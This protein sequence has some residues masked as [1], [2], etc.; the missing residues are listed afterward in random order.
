M[1]RLASTA[2]K[3][4]KAEL[5]FCDELTGSGACCTLLSGSY[6][7]G[8]EHQHSDVDVIVIGQA[9]EAMRTPDDREVLR[10]LRYIDG[11]R[12]EIEYYQP[13]FIA[14][15][16]NA[17]SEER[18]AMAKG[19]D[20]LSVLGAY[21]LSRALRLHDGVPLSGPELAES[22]K[23]QLSAAG[24]AEVV[25][26][27]AVHECDA[28]VD[29][30][31]GL[32]AAGDL[33]SAVLA[34]AV[35]LGYAIDACLA[36]HGQLTPGAKWRYRKYLLLTEREKPGELPMTAEKC[37]RLLTLADL[38]TSNAD[39]WVHDIVGKCQQVIFEVTE[40]A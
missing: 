37:W 11:K 39:A 27:L 16:A 30:A 22:C 28:A 25:T 4:T 14:R 13:G 1:N 35:A 21:R 20:P 34:A 26:G 2:V 29:D 32:L 12:W 7:R 3:F 33:Q 38:E 10:H 19:G 8:W 18:A 5:A 17:V 40:K 23:R 9:P 24:L 6:A 31:L 36:W 15:L